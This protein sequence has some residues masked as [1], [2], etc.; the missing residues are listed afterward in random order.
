VPLAAILCRLQNRPVRA[1][2]M[3]LCE[4]PRG[5]WS[6]HLALWLTLGTAAE[7]GLSGRRRGGGGCGRRLPQDHRALTL[8]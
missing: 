4:S 2:Q 3:R 6:E 1:K 5:L 8:E 7:V